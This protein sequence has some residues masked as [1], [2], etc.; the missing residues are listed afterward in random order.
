MASTASWSTH[1]ALDF[2]DAFRH[3]SRMNASKGLTPGFP[4]Q[5]RLVQQNFSAVRTPELVN[6]NTQPG[7]N[8]PT[9]FQPP[10]WLFDGMIPDVAF[11]SISDTR[12]TSSMKTIAFILAIIG[13]ILIFGN[14][15]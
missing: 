7:P 10:P 15:R 1:P 8:I 14:R 11:N 9:H 12:Q 6:V 4:N 2:S 13:L 5:F 3:A